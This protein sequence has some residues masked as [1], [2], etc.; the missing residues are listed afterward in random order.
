MSRW[1]PLSS[2]YC[3]IFHVWAFIA[4]Y[5][6]LI[7]WSFQHISEA[8]DLLFGQMTTR[9]HNPPS[10]REQCKPVVDSKQMTTRGKKNKNDRPKN[11]FLVRQGSWSW[12]SKQCSKGKWSH[13]VNLK[14]CVVTKGNLTKASL[15]HT[16]HLSLFHLST[17]NPSFFKDTVAFIYKLKK[18]NKRFLKTL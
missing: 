16:L 7:C 13:P 12:A 1:L 18:Q 10:G 14:P 15:W 8:F 2:Q 9:N 11:K 5:L 3:S 4:L 6:S 17:L